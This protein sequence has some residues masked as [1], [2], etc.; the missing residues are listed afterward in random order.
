MK[1]LILTILCIFITTS[2]ASADYRRVIAKKNAAGGCNLDTF[3]DFFEEDSYEADDIDQ[4]DISSVSTW[5]NGTTQDNA[6]CD[7]SLDP[8]RCCTGSGTGKCGQSLTQETPSSKPVYY[9]TDGPNNTP[10]V[11]FNGIGDNLVNSFGVH[12]QPNSYVLIAKYH[13]SNAGE[14]IMGTPHGSIKQNIG[15][16][17]SNEW[18]IDAGIELTN[19]TAADTSYH[20]FFVHFNGASSELEIDGVQDISGNAGSDN[21]QDMNMGKTDTGAAKVTISAFGLYSGD[22][23]EDE[24]WG[25]L[26]TYINNKWGL[27]IEP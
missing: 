7:A 21:F 6:D 1:K 8:Y 3:H 22:A 9:T 23:R 11:E 17:A 4:S 2:I 20:A 25:C 26:Q 14:D 27:D 19:N 16:N 13:T 18:W 10:A 24:N 15:T 5:V 12:N